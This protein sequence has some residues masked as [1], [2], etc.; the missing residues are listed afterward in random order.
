MEAK[1]TPKR[2]IGVIRAI[3]GMVPQKT[4]IHEI[5]ERFIGGHRG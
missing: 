2:L 1:L 3:G 5:L 4:Q